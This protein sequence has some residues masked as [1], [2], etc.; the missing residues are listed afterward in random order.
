[1]VTKKHKG[2]ISIILIV[3]LFISA[4]SI[5]FSTAYTSYEEED[6]NG[7]ESIDGIENE[8]DIG[9]DSGIKEG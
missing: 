5:P 4:L 9:L 3:L 7:Y 2:L 8:G 6:S 1:M